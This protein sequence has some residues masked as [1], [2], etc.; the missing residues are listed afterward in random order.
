MQ[1]KFGHGGRGDR[2]GDAGGIRRVGNAAN[3]FCNFILL[4]R[5]Q[6][7]VINN[8]ISKTTMNSAQFIFF[9]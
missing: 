1:G 2:A 8:T 9:V 6:G 7:R 4:R 5:M 3:A